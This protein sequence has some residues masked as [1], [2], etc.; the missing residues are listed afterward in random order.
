MLLPLLAVVFGLS[1]MD[2]VKSVGLPVLAILGIMILL[3]TLALVA[4]LY[5][6]LEL[7]DPTQ[8]LALP[9]GS[10]RAVIAL[11][12]IVLFA[13]ISIT[14]YRSTAKGG[15][16]Y[17]VSSLTE[18][19]RNAL[20]LQSGVRVQDVLFDYCT[21]AAQDSGAITRNTSGGAR[22]AGD[23][24]SAVAQERA[25]PRE[26]RRYQVNLRASPSPE[27]G[28]LAKQLLV[29]VGTLMTS[30]T[31]FY[32]AARSKS[33]DKPPEPSTDN[34]NNTPGSPNGGQDAQSTR[35]ATPEDVRKDGTN[36]GQADN[37]GGSK[38]DNSP[39]GQAT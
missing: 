9:Q 37:A 10:M 17:S 32:F 15:G 25:C 11:S 30:V 13:I 28:D 23:A 26:H 7:T 16:I 19:A 36:S 35:Q 20:L 34:A 33:D 29:L 2:D 6:R 4:M 8:P 3:G 21:D 31:S 1:G 39:P 22:S 14:L 38:G 27:S 18:D 24:A 5:K 12:L